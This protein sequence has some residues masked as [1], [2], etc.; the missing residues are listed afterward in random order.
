MGILLV[1]CSNRGDPNM[2]LTE[3]STLSTAALDYDSTMIDALELSS[4]NQV[5][6]VP[7]PDVKKH[8]RNVVEP[9]GPGLAALIERLKAR[10]GAEAGRLRA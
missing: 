1:C 2:R 3:H 9:N 8:S 7:H 6:A 5:F 4:K 10:S